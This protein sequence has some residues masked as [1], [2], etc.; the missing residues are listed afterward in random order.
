MALSIFL[1]G[2]RKASCITVW[3]HSYKMVCLVPPEEG[4]DM[5]GDSDFYSIVPSRL[6][7]V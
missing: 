3:L 6:D 7:F 4:V 1:N 5:E 2:K